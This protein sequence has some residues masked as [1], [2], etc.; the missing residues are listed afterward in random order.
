VL[1]EIL[2]LPH[3]DERWPSEGAPARVAEAPTDTQSQRLRAMVDA[4]FDPLW[5]FMR[6]L[7]VATMDLDDAMQEVIMIAASRLDVIPKESE[8]A[9]LFGTAF[10]VASEWRRFRGGRREVALEHLAEHEDPMPVA[11]ALLDQA[12]ART[13]LDRVLEE[14]PL[15]LRAV[16]TL[17]EIEELTMAE[18][19]SLLELP[20]GT[21]A[22]RLRR[23]RELFESQVARLQARSTRTR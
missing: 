23:G 13:L 7:G 5:R 8:K 9:F 15:D 20:A 18:I 17:Y 1:P 21:V 14:M 22:S 3:A 16:F 19:A 12:R 10:R 11:D 6:R 2:T 4:H